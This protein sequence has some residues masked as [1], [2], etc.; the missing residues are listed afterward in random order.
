MKSYQSQKTLVIMLM[1]MGWFVGANSK[2]QVSPQKYIK[3]TTI[4]D[5]REVVHIEVPGTKP[6]TFRMPLA[7]PTESAVV[8]SNVPAYDWSFGCS[9]TAG[10]MMAGY[11]DNNGYP[12]VYTGPTNGGVAPLNNSI[13]GTAIINGEERSLCPLSATRLGL[14][15][16][17]TRGHVDDYWIQSG[18]N[19]PD[20]Y[21]ANGWTQHTYGDCT[22]DFMKTN[23][24][25]F[26]NSD[27]ST[28]FTF[29]T[30]GGAFGAV[31]DGDGGYGLKLF[32]E[33]RGCPV[34]GYYNQYI[35]GYNGLTK[36]FT[37][38]DYV[39]M[40]DMG[41]PVLIQ[42]SG[43]T[44]LGMGYDL[45]GNKVLL[46]DTWDYG[47]HE[48]VWGDS[49]AGMQHYAVTVVAFPCPAV[50]S[51][52]ESFNSFSFPLCWSQSH[53][54]VLDVDRWSLATSNNAGGTAN[55]MRCDWIDKV[56]TSRLITKLI[57]TTGAS[58]AN[59]SFTTFF[60][61]YGSGATIKI[62]SSSDLLTWTDEAWSYATGTGDIAAGTIINTSIT[63]N[64]GPTTYVAWVI[65]G[66]HYQFDNWFI[67]DV[68]ITAP[69]TG[70]QLQLSLYLEGLY[71]G[72][73]LNQAQNAS[74]AQFGAG[75]ADQLSIEL[76]DATSPYALVGTAY[77]ANLSTS[78]LATIN[79]SGS[80]SGSY[81][82]VVKHRNHLETWAAAPVSFAGSAITYSFTDAA[83]KAYGNR[84]KHLGEGVYG[85]YA[86]DVNA[87]GTINLADQT[88][89]AASA[90]SFAT[91]YLT[92]DANGDGIIDAKDLILIDN[93]AANAVS[94]AHP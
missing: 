10:A 83:N 81:Y 49:Y 62:Q 18:N 45:T 74:T 27:G 2:A 25:G 9:A 6:P 65:D 8:L 61:D 5:G 24:S 55:E 63:H 53:E 69:I 42:V 92:N 68:N 51:L 70:K 57:N 48:M 58:Q 40:I 22:G 35:L 28:I 31:S 72:A 71:N 4:V 7:A 87:S 14:D 77:T 37:F 15:G 66:D 67:D 3:A 46:H 33:S 89:A 75:I 80:L 54:G 17:S 19:D 20:P 12:N 56:G 59:L 23:Q 90:A 88:T 73:G 38:A 82:V 29:Y 39:A 32:F 26:G 86:G 60:D 52:A 50:N 79:L 16:R 76:H 93:N 91:G 13:W 1:L 64:L 44:M 85:I 78:G 47:T 21:I 41:F 43:H 36:G 30:D 94:V 34:T 11:Y 84:L